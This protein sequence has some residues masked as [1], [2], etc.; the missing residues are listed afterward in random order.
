MK[1]SRER[2]EGED[3]MLALGGC[4]I[5]AKLTNCSA[6]GHLGGRRQT[7]LLWLNCCTQW[8]NQRWAA[9]SQFVGHEV[10]ERVL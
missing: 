5:A 10:K 6:G 9:M 1:D 2:D 8:T 4:V 7:C 3:K